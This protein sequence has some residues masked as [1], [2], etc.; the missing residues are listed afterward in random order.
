VISIEIGAIFCVMARGFLL[1]RSEIQFFLAPFYWG[2]TLPKE[3]AF[4]LA[5][6]VQYTF[7]T[8]LFKRG[9]FRF[10]PIVGAFD[11]IIMWVLAKYVETVSRLPARKPNLH[12]FNYHTVYGT[13]HCAM[14]CVLS[15]SLPI[16]LL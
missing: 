2:V 5:I 13:V 6:G 8:R 11:N 16:L 9:I 3:N 7:I 1:S 14:L 12:I 10:E 15:T 4:S